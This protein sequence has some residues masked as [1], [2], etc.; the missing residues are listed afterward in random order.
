MT[1]VT[2]ETYDKG[3]HVPVVV[4]TH[5]ETTELRHGEILSFMGKNWRVEILNKE[6]LDGERQ[7]YLIEARA[8]LVPDT[9]EPSAHEVFALIDQLRK[10]IADLQST[11]DNGWPEGPGDPSNIAYFS[12]MAHAAGKAIA[13]SKT[14]LEQHLANLGSRTVDYGFGYDPVHLLFDVPQ[15]ERP[16]WGECSPPY[17]MADDDQD[18]HYPC[19]PGPPYYSEDY[20]NYVSGG[21]PGYTP[22]SPEYVP[23]SPAY[24]PGYSPTSVS[25]SPSSPP[26]P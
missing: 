16:T 14:V 20:G 15:S 25:Y 1:K 18:Y 10:R 12:A 4:E 21:T 11:Y 3:A 24:S 13:D 8:T 6:D 5:S 17:K 2:F 9:S 26:H 23:S 7:V 19:E 22:T